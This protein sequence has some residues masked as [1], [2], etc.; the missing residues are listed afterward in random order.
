MT[1]KTIPYDVAE[2]LRTPTEVAAYVKAW[3]DEAPDD[4]VGCAR[5]LRNVIRA[6]GMRVVGGQR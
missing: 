5:A 6:I 1:T 4:V 3:L 2:Q